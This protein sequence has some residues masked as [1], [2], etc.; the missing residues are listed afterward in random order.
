MS[1]SKKYVQSGLA[2]AITLSLSACVMDEGDLGDGDLGETIQST[3]QASIDRGRDIWFKNTYG[4]EKFFF[5][6]KTQAP[7]QNR[8][9]IGFRNVLDT[10][11]AVRHD[12]WGVVNDPDCVADPDGGWDLCPDPLASGVVGI[13]KFETPVGTLF[14]VA[15]ASCHAGFDPVNPPANPNDPSWDNIHPTIG[16]QNLKIGNLFA[17]NLPP[18]DVRRLV[19]ATWPDG[20]VDTTALF[21]DGINNPGTIT[22]FWEHPDRKRF[23]VGMDEPK[24]RN[25]QGGEDDVGGDLAALRVFGNIGVCFQECVAPAVATG[26]PIDVAACY[27]NCPDYPPQQDLDD[28]GNFLAT[29][30]APK[31]PGHAVPGIALIGRKVF[32]KNCASCHV[33]SG[34]GGKVLSNDEVNSLASMGANATNACRALTTNWDEGKLWAQFS[35]DV[36]KG[37][38]QAGKGYRTMPLTGIWATAPFLHNQ[39]ITGHLVPH[40]GSVPASVSPHVRALYYWDAMWELL[41]GP[42]ERTPWVNV[43]P[44]PLQMP[45]GQ[46]GVITIP[47]GTPLELVINGGRCDDFIQNR[48]HYYGSHLSDLEKFALIYWLKFQ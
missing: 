41:S 6:L 17:V 35:S 38:G 19:F 11:R 21:S 5:W 29:A 36:Y 33:T 25:G 32:Q 20:A 28:M 18:D 47:A 16:A 13:R 14:G 26:Q 46:G 15:C 1:S 45:D 12:V 10:P 40:G 22:A 8:I 37:R 23:H 7:P 34:P 27:Q 39:S 48:G 24:M 31:Y 3:T 44:V 2:L 9:D 30:K 4:G 43:T 42:S